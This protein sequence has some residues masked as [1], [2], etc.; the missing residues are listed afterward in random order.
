[1]IK[2]IIFDS[3][4]TLVDSET[5]S[6]EVIVELLAE[7]GKTIRYH[8]ALERFRGSEFAK[9][10]AKLDADYGLFADA[11]DLTEFTHAFRERGKQRYAE[12]LQPIPGAV[13][14][15]RSITLPKCVASNGPR[16]KLDVCLGAAGLLPYFEGFVFSAYE[17]GS[18]K[19]DPGLILHA[20]A[21]MGV[22]PE[23]CLLVEDSVAGIEAGLAAGVEV[24]GY[25]L[26]DDVKARLSRQ[27]PII[28]RLAD[29]RRYLPD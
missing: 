20:A 3:D 26:E 18:W 17:V 29:V 6:A 27:V 8:E 11:A 12:S 13:E 22:P 19:P 10:A 7:R 24:V 23:Q 4:G 21:A 16:D 14:L 25:R 15:V 9:F 2:G 1:M 5:L 28:D